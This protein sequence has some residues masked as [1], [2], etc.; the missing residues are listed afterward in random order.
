[1]LVVW[2]ALWFSKHVLYTPLLLDDM[3]GV[4]FLFFLVFLKVI[5][6]LDNIK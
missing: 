4:V 5:V 1:M 2:V 6:W 3:L